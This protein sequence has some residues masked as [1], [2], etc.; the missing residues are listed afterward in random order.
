MGQVAGP[1]P[2]NQSSESSAGT[3]GQKLTAE[4]ANSVR[5]LGI[6]PGEETLQN[7]ESLD[8][9]R[10]EMEANPGIASETNPLDQLKSGAPFSG[11]MDNLL[12]VVMHTNRLQ[13]DGS[14]AAIDL[15]L[16]SPENLNSPNFG[17]D[18]KEIEAIR[19]ETEVSV[20]ITVVV[21]SSLSRDE[22]AAFVENIKKAFESRHP[23]VEIQTKTVSVD[24]K[25]L[26]NQAIS[27]N[28][29]IAEALQESVQELN[30]GQVPYELS[31]LARTKAFLAQST[32]DFLFSLEHMT[33]QT[34]YFAALARKMVEK[35]NKQLAGFKEWSRDFSI[36]IKRL[37]HWK[38]WT[39]R[40]KDMFV[41]GVVVGGGKSTLSVSYWLTVTGVNTFGVLQAGMSL[42]L[43]VFFAA[44]GNKVESWKGS[45]QFPLLKK[46]KIVQ[47]YNNTPL[48]KAFIIGN[49]ISFSAGFYFRLWSHLNDPRNV[50]SPWSVEALGT[51]FGAMSIGGLIGSAGGQG[52]LTLRRKN[53]ISARQEML[54]YQIYGIKMQIEGFLFGSGL[55]SLFWMFFAG[56]M[57]IQSSIY[58]ASRLLPTRTPR[59]LVLHPDVLKNPAVV[60]S[61]LYTTGI[62]DHKRMTD[63][64]EISQQKRV[65]EDKTLWQK[66]EVLQAKI[67]GGICKSILRK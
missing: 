31:S 41:A 34:A 10:Q 56:N 27:A 19:P 53:W 42:F 24:I 23:N 13:A 59:V 60:E 5:Q 26:E 54:L 14:V 67:R 65:A 21:P 15:G 1:K 25:G 30:Q 44:W 18:G 61:E 2:P 48:L 28:D 33:V 39:V 12:K 29:S 35:N 58:G 38:N 51:Y 6:K 55:T 45:H 3:E 57:A 11:D 40:E 32:K 9:L 46:S 16:L 8:P 37:R 66:L 62:L 7:V 63:F 47:W 64:T 4:Q 17:F 20:S 50:T 43:D 36:R 22:E 52:A 49:M